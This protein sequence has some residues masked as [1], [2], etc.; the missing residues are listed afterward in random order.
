MACNG[1]IVIHVANALKNVRYF[2][3]CLNLLVKVGYR[4]KGKT[5]KN[6]V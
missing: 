1:F 4:L 3:P 2:E 5:T 6:R